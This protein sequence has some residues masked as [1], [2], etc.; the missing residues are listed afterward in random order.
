MPDPQNSEI[1][2]LEHLGWIDRVSAMTCSKYGVWGAEAEDFASFI[3]MKL[4][5]DEYAII[6]KF[7]AESGLKTYLAT[8]VVRQFHD[9]WRERRG[10]WRRSAAA[11][12]LGPPAGELETLV[13]RD[14]YRL[15]QAGEKLRTSGQTTLSNG[16]LARLL[17]KLPR[18]EPLRP[19]EVSPEVMVDAADATQRAD[20]RVAG[21]ETAALQDRVMGALRRALEHLEPEDQMIV[22]MHFG[23][24]RTLAEVA[25]TLHL[26]QKPLYR[27]VERL[28]LKLRGYLEQD[29]V[30]GEDVQ[31]VVGE[32][33]VP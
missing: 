8:V 15:D 20:D 5:E 1:L 23:D 27:K 7:R 19:R 3:R 2:F 22:R 33:E 11:E 16:E 18:R 6:R 29:G 9:Y 24:G 30:Q 10:R 13:Y 25:R 31:G 12:R 26:E 28:R 17:E 14:G 21:A 4:M 32:R